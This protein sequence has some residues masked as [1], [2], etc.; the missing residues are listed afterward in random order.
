[1]NRVNRTGRS[2]KAPRHV[3]LYYWMMDTPA[4]RSLNGNE[5][6]TLV[7]IMRR[8]DGSNNGRIPY[9]V[10]DVEDNL[11]VSKAT[12]SRILKRLEQRG[13]IATMTKGAF[14]LKRRHATEWR[15]SEFNCDL[16]HAM[17]SKQF[18]KWSPEIQ[19]TVPVVKQ[20]VPV[21]KPFRTC[22]ETVRLENDPDGTCGETVKR[23]IS[24]SRF[25]QR[26]TNKL[27]GRG[28]PIGETS[29]LETDRPETGAPSKPEASL[30]PPLGAKH[31]GIQNVGDDMADERD[32]AEM[33]RVLRQTF[34]NRATCAE[35]QQHMEAFAGPRWSRPSFYR[36]LSVIKEKGQVRVVDGGNGKSISPTEKVKR[37]DFYEA[38][39]LDDPRSVSSVSEQSRAPEAMDEAADAAV[40]AAMELLQRLNRS[41][42]P[43]AA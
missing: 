11:R 8:Y 22:G 32:L 35:W 28:E 27:P 20:S 33:I 36:R 42:P 15:L 41:K 4:W 13:F 18:A 25:H 12:G 14:S 43:T 7:D 30:R 23:K 40:K 6:A 37:G 2:N 16:T 38:T 21:V 26:Y 19:N 39:I 9:S 29:E 24:V 5:R 10:R 1:M 31:D 17:P 34:G 3:R